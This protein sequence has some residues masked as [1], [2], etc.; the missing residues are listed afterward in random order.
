LL[1]LPTTSDSFL[2]TTAFG[3]SHNCSVIF[4][5][6]ILDFGLFDDYPAYIMNKV[7]GFKNWYDSLMGKL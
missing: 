6:F 2:K 5:E 3:L 7:L 4:G 1:F